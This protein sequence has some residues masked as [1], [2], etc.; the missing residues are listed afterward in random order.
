MSKFKIHLQGE[1]RA[2]CG[3]VSVVHALDKKEFADLTKN[4]TMRHHAC[5]KCIEKL[6]TT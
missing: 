6:S 3:I 4:K 5:K 1:G 2:A